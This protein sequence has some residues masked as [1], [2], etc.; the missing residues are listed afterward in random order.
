M[1]NKLRSALRIVAVLLVL[2]A[3]LMRLD[4]I[5]IPALAGIGF[6]MVVIA[7]SLIAVSS[8]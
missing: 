8:K 6:W 1:N 4:I 5:I 7:F 3:V 2:V